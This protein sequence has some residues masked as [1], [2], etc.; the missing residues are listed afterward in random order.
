M[1]T[2]IGRR[3]F[4][5]GLAALVASL[6]AF[7]LPGASDAQQ[8]ALPRRIGVILV[9]FSPESKEPQQFRH[10]LQDA[11]YA[12][13]RDVVIEWRYANGD[14]TRVP[15][16]VADLVQSKV[17]A[18][19]VDST[20]TTQVAKRSTSTIPIVMA[21]VADP[22]GSGLVTNLARPGGNV[23]GLSQMTADLSAKRLQ[24]LKETIP[25]IA[26]VAVLWNP[27]TPYHSKV[28]E[29]LKAAAPSLSI[30]LSF[31]GVRT[32]EQFGSVLSAVSRADAQALYVIDDPF[33]D[34]H[35]TTI[36][37]LASKARLPT[38]F[39]QRE[40]VDEGG[41][42]S[43][44][45]SYADLFRRSAGYVDR[46]LKGM[47]PGDLPIEQPTKFEFVVN[48]R[49][50]KTIGVAIPQSVLIQADDIIK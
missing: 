17:D 25:R 14:Y 16:L 20:V 28:I 12:E 2:R 10:G 36:S 34:I 37:K 27:D 50:A 11:G 45:A 26:R 41:L 44:G 4:A 47:K 22:V 23:T 24:L 19:V 6:G 49:T 9:G 31:V 15:E 38:T 7:C 21:L 13:G 30:K 35:R 3:T 33:F 29:D 40:Y 42:M 43:Y 46:I 39:G 5:C 18:I 8:P 32:P 48:L 1:T